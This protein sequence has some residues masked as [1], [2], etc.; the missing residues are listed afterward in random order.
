[1]TI[2]KYQENNKMGSEGEFSNEKLM[3]VI[4][5]VRNKLNENTQS[6]AK[7]TTSIEEI[8]EQHTD[9]KTELMSLK[10]NT[11]AQIKALEASQQSITDSQKFLNGEFEEYKVRLDAA[12]ERS[13]SAEANIIKS[14]A[15]MQ[16]I[17]EDLLTQQNNINSL[18]Q[19]GRRNMLEINNIPEKDNENLKSII[20]AIASEMNLEEFNYN[21]DVDIAHRLQCKLPISPII[22]LFNNRT[23]I[24]LLKGTTLKDLK[25]L[26]FTENQPIFIN[27]SL[28]L[29]NRIL[30][31]KVRE[32]CKKQHYKFFWTSNGISMCKKN[33]QSDVVIMKNERDIERIK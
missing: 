11:Q 33:V 31:K 30:F 13:K 15:D 16:I 22:V 3:E 5:D 28:T 4:L 19:Y 8:K 25:E 24:K 6:I 10:T 20:I 9:I 21:A 2:E 17:H 18:E 1:M 7:L 14:K 23:R 32:A 27:E 29:F 12:E 26:N